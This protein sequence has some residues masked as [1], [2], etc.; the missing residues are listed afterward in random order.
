VDRIEREVVIEA[1]QER[2]WELLTEAEHL[3]TWFGDAGAE[4]DLRVGG[5]LVMHWKE[6][7]TT[8]ARIERIEEPSR[9]AFRWAPFKDP[10]GT[11]PIEGNSTQVDFTLAAEGGATRVRVV[12]SG[13]DTLACPPEQRER[14]LAGNT[15]GWAFELGQLAEHATRQPVR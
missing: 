11:E 14:N 8:H 10:G 5:S 12:E 13:F 7:G 2:V 15:D 1:P 3:G 4:I 6:H 9:F